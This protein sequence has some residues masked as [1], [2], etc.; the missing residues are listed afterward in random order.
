[1]Q[2]TTAEDYIN[3]KII[4]PIKFQ[5]D[6]CDKLFQ[7]I[8]KYKHVALYK[9]N[10]KDYCTLKCRNRCSAEQKRGQFQPCGN[11]GKDVY[12]RNSHIKK[13]K[14]GFCNHH[15]S[16]T[17]NNKLRSLGKPPKPVK[18]PR[19]RK[20]SAPK[21]K[22]L[23]SKEI[24]E[25]NPQQCKACGT[26]LVYE[27]CRVIVISGIR[28]GSRRQTCNEICLKASLS[29]AG[30]KSA[31][32]QSKDRRSV[33][34]IDFADKCKEKFQNVL[35]NIPMFNGWDADVI[36]PDI[37]VAILWNGPWHYK[38]ITK[39]HSVS[40]VQNRDQYKMRMIKEAGYYP[41][42]IKDMGKKNKKFVTKQ[43]NQFLEFI[44]APNPAGKL[45]S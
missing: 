31:A 5:C 45:L 32:L 35:T 1:M 2:L 9:G 42:V 20:P 28:T 7:R 13:Y 16:A 14:N 33:N 3:A 8:K 10:I 40:Q 41:Y 39:R 44:N 24:Y 23:S 15:C 26:K 43:F 27:N 11:C 38:K 34:E 17:F 22:G 4:D 29:S 37:K 19:I 6:G 12:R 18:P 36:L 30:R 21:P 25:L